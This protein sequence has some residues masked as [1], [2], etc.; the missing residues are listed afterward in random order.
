MINN[1]NSP[2]GETK[3]RDRDELEEALFDAHTDLDIIGEKSYEGLDDEGRKA[4]AAEY[5]VGCRRLDT[6]YAERDFLDAVDEMDER[7]G[8]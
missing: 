7:I 5:E 2:Q 8:R 3:M 6:L 1:N 4:L